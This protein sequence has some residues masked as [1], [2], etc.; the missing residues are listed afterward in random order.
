MHCV[1]E[2]DVI[3]EVRE[4]SFGLVEILFHRAVGFE[5]GAFGQGVEVDRSHFKPGGPPGCRATLICLRTIA[6]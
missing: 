5:I 3:Q 2:T 6:R 1:G 4:G